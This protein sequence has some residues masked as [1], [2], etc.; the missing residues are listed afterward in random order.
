MHHRSIPVNT[1]SPMTLLLPSS[2]M[3]RGVGRKFCFGAQ[4]NSLMRCFWKLEM[5]RK[6]FIRSLCERTAQ[7]K[8]LLNVSAVLLL[9]RFEALYHLPL[10]SNAV[11]RFPIS[12]LIHSS[13]VWLAFE[14]PCALLL[15][16]L[17][18]LLV[19]LV[20]FQQKA[21][22]PVSRL[23]HVKIGIRQTFGKAS[24]L[25]WQEEAVR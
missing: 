5:G 22:V 3:I 15:E 20:E 21:V 25:T 13:H 1:G 18:N 8:Q 6:S 10:L 2:P 11:V 7:Q 16:M 9:Y 17:N 19:H 4:L 12:H 24:L 14:D 23:Q